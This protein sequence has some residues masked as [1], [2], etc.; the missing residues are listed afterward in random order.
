VC[1]EFGHIPSEGE[2]SKGTIC[3]G[4]GQ[5]REP[6]KYIPRH[7]CPTLPPDVFAGR[8]ANLPLSD[9]VGGVGNDASIIIAR[10][11]C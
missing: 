2:L 11:R 3:Y 1:P 7:R 10:I 5:H 8:G 4:E 9:V 6:C